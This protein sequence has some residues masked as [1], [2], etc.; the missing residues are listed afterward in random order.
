M[1]GNIVTV[2]RYEKLNVTSGGSVER[3]DGVGQFAEENYKQTQK[4]RREA[5]RNLCTTNFD[6]HSKFLTLT[7]KNGVVDYKNV[8]ECNRLFKQFI[9]RMRRRYGDFK[10]LAVIGFQDKNGRGAVHYHMLSDLPYIPKSELA[11]LW[12]YG[13]VKINDIENVDNV[14]AYVSKYMAED[15]DDTRLQGL[16]AYQHSRNLDKPIELCNW[17]SS[18]TEI[19]FGSIHERLE[20]KS[21]SYS[22]KYESEYA[23]VVEFI[24][25]NLSK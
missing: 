12:G 18:D 6:N 11:T 3:P 10:Y 19:D 25:Y 24:Q 13:F 2:R 5:V 1:A 20:K 8:K 9:Q 22:A 23:G 15:L 21:P 4:K 14:G 16:K 17:R 7:F